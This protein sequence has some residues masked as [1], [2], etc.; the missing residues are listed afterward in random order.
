MALEVA[1]TTAKDVVGESDD[2]DTD[3]TFCDETD[4]EEYAVSSESHGDN[5]P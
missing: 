3:A 1:T 4:L 5:K 2:E